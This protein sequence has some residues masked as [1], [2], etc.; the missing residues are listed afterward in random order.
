MDVGET[1]AAILG[2]V[3]DHGSA[4][5]ELKQLEQLTHFGGARNNLRYELCR[6]KSN[7]KINHDNDTHQWPF[8]PV[9]K[10]LWRFDFAVPL[11]GAVVVVVAAAA[12][13]VGPFVGSDL[14]FFKRFR[15]NTDWFNCQ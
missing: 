13:P 7:E 9:A 3:F 10:Q 14:T 2:D 6:E 8:A 4:I 5:R 1:F 15:V 11:A 12:D